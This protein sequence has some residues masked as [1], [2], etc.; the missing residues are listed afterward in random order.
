[1][2]AG[3]QELGKTYLK[4]SQFQVEFTLGHICKCFKIK[5]LAWSNLGEERSGR[6]TG[7]TL[8]FTRFTTD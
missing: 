1:M 2:G 8:F 3:Q 5:M 7:N 4:L 6:K